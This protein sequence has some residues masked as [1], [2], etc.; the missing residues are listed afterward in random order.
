MEVNEKVIS[1]DNFQTYTINP[2]DTIEILRYVG[3][4]SHKPNKKIISYFTF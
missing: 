3:G 1:K 2:N 4:G